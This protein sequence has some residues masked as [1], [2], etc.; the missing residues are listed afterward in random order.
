MYAAYLLVILLVDMLPSTDTLIN[1][2]VKNIFPFLFVFSSFSLPYK[3][4]IM[5]GILKGSPKSHLTIP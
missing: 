4:K 3:Q 5:M 1:L 2:K